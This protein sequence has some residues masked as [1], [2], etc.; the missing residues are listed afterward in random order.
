MNITPA[1]AWLVALVLIG[2]AIIDGVKL[3]VPNWLTYPLAFG[4]LFFHAWTGGLPGLGLSAVGLVAGLFLLLPLY[5]IGG[6]GAGDVKLLAGVGA[7]MGA[8]TTFWAFA[9]SAI[10]GGA[11]GLA[12]MAVGGFWKHAAMFETIGREILTVRDPIKLSETAAAR[13]SKM[14]LLPYGIPIALGSIGYFAW[15]GFF[16]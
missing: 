16:F 6:M 10:I 2:A 9:C 14:M 15:V 1:T 5:A 11:I 13:K 3:K 8:V 12:M 7:W 4:G